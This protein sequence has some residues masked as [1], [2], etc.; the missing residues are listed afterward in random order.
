MVYIYIYN[1]CSR[2]PPTLQNMKPLKGIEFA[3]FDVYKAEYNVRRDPIFEMETLMDTHQSKRLEA[4]P[5]MTLAGPN[6][7]LTTKLVSQMGS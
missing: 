4:Q 7:P 3:D 2:P 6:W 1:T 5:P